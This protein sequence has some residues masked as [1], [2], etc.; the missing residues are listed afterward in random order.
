MCGIISP[1]QGVFEEDG[2]SQPLAVIV[3]IIWFEPRTTYIH[4]YLFVDLDL[5]DNPNTRRTYM[6][7]AGVA[8]QRI[9]RGLRSYTTRTPEI[10]HRTHA[11]AAAVAAAITSRTPG[12]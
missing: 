4:A 2:K 3:S 11:A 7:L 5:T 8:I 12:E 1:S 6:H 10:A 9:A